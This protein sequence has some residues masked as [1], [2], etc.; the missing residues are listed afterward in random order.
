[1]EPFADK[2]IDDS[3]PAR[4]YAWSVSIGKT[5]NKW[6]FVAS[7][8]QVS[9]WVGVLWQAFGNLNNGG[10]AGAFYVNGNN[11]LGNL[12]SLN[13]QIFVDFSASKL[14]SSSFR[15]LAVNAMELLVT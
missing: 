6:G 15:A 2:G 5:I 3:L 14:A 8:P 11:T 10:N 1:L 12:Y 13:V 9:F 7:G 4:I